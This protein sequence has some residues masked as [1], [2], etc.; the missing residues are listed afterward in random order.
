MGVGLCVRENVW[1]IGTGD[2]FHAFFSTV[3]A[4]LEPGGWGTRFPTVMRELYSGE[5]APDDA[6]RALA[7]LDQIRAELRRLPPSDIVWDVADRTKRPPWGEDISDEI[8]DL[9]NYFVT[10]DGRDLF[11]VLGAALGYASRAGAPLRVR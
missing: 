5:L 1:P 11:D 10:E 4:R 8:T 7:E 9:S 6:A 3:C 2:F